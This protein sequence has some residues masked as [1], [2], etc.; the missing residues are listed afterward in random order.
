MIKQYPRQPKAAE[1]DEEGDGGYHQT[2][3]NLPEQ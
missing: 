2:D 1:N 3:N